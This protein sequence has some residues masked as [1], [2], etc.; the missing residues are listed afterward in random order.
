M[1]DESNVPPLRPR[2]Q[3]SQRHLRAALIAIAA[4]AITLFPVVDSYA[5]RIVTMGRV[6]VPMTAVRPPAVDVPRFSGSDMPRFSGSDLPRNPVGVSP[7]VPG[8]PG[9]INVI[10]SGRYAPGRRA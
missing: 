3:S 5:Q 10:P 2:R 7:R 8:G 6:N 9:G 1:F 4:G